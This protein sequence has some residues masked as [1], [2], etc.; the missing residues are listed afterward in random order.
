VV[1]SLLQSFASSNRDMERPP[2]LFLF[3]QGDA[4]LAVA[5]WVGNRQSFVG[6]AEHHNT[7][8]R[9]ASD[10]ASCLNRNVKSRNAPWRFFSMSAWSSLQCLKWCSFF[11][12]FLTPSVCSSITQGSTSGCGTP[13]VS[14]EFESL[15]SHKGCPC[16]TGTTD[17]NSGMKV[18]SSPQ[19]AIFPVTLWVARVLLSFACLYLFF[20][21]CGCGVEIDFDEQFMLIHVNIHEISV[22]WFWLML[23]KAVDFASGM[24]SESPYAVRLWRTQMMLNVYSSLVPPGGNWEGQW[25]GSYDFSRLFTLL[26]I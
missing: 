20:C 24:A 26:A 15:L 4:Y 22:D 3:A 1:S 21:C 17:S 19:L 5:P 11:L 12:S 8:V 6:D 10:A 7:L 16:P 14:D 9:P 25:T 2:F 18:G 13:P 23:T